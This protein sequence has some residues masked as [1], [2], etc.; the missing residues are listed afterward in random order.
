MEEKRALKE[1]IANRE[2]ENT[3]IREKLREINK[4]LVKL[5]HDKEIESKEKEVILILS[6]IEEISLI[7][8]L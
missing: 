4:E 1:I 5:K 8:K 3:E 7:K 2:T 6:Y